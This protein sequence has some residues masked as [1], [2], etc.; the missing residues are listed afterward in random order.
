MQITIQYPPDD[1]PMTAHTD[2][3]TISILLVE[4]Q[5]VI[6]MD[7]MMRLR[8]R[9]YEVETTTSG[10]EALARFTRESDRRSNGDQPFDLVLMDIDLGAGMDGPTTAEL[11]LQVADI[12]IV[13]LTSH[14]EQEM[15][16]RVRSITRYGYVL[17][18]SGDFVL[19]S[20]IEM[21]LTLFRTY[22]EAERDRDELRAL[23]EHAPIGLLL[24]DDALQVRKSNHVW[25]EKGREVTEHKGHPRTRAIGEALECIRRLDDPRGCGY[26]PSCEMCRIRRTVRSTHDSG[27]AY[28]DVEADIIRDN[29]RNV[30]LKKHTVL[31]STAPLELRGES[32]V[33]V[34]ISDITSL[35]S[36]R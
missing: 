27:I 36:P 2:T 13:F 10:E 15:V 7:E 31:I 6:A 12:P 29:D 25:L 14:S 17:K 23:Y 19:T 1:K 35:R 4:D 34:S 5:S 32:L 11:I 28:G 8:R 21:A 18:S 24:V 9:G 33:L 26:G 30:P 16:D 20:A 3:E 22:R